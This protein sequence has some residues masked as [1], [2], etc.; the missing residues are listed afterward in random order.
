MWNSMYSVNLSFMLTN[1]D[2]FLL[3]CE[4][5]VFD[6]LHFFGWFGFKSHASPAAHTTI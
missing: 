1:A 4:L 2:L 3:I 6:M 5:L